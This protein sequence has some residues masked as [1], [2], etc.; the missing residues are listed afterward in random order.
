MKLYLLFLLGC[1]PALTQ[2]QYKVVFVLKQVPGAHSKEAVFAAGN[3][4]GWNPGSTTHQFQNK[5]EEPALELSLQ[6]GNYEF[7]CT[8][9]NW[10]QVEVQR[11]GS[12]IGNRSI[13]VQSDTVFHISIEAWKD[14]F[15]PP[16]PRQHTAS[17]NVTVLSDSFFMPQLDR[18]RRIWLY[19]PAGYSAG[20]KRYPVLYMHDGQNLFDEMT[21]PF[22]EWGVDECLDSLVKKGSKE[23]IVVGIDHGNGKRMTEYNPYGFRNFGEGEGNKYVDFLAQT[24]K[25]YIDEHYRTQPGKESTTVAGSSMG[26][27]ISLYALLKYPGVF[28]GGGIFSPAFWTAP[29]LDKYID[30]LPGKIHA[31]LFFYAG[32]QESTEM[33]V[34]MERI[35]D[36]LA[37]K[38]DYF[39]YSVVDPEGKHNEAA[40]RRWLPVFYGWMFENRAE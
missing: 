38:S 3:F 7:K 4:N 28:G 21:A 33:T 36:K 17:A 35:A 25:P 10:Q 12:D 20:N 27:L 2:A 23:C 29:Q 39:I 9:G 37:L 34:D 26:G 32:G 22:G 40:W 24:L 30:S 11:N 14:D 5:G 13:T 1:C 31:R 19:L 6:P 15:G 16:P 8:R 18:S